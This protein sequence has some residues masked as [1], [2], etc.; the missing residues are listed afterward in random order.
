M[1][2]NVRHKNLWYSH[3]HKN[4]KIKYEKIWYTIMYQIDSPVSINIRIVGTSRTSM[5]IFVLSL[6]LSDMP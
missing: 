6:H 3:R 2:G 1:W 4:D 5:F